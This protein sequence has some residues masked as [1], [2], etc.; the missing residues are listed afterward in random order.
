VELGTLVIVGVT[1]DPWEG[2]ATRNLGSS[3]SFCPL[4]WGNLKLSFYKGKREKY[5]SILFDVFKPRHWL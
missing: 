1:V 4:P 2:N 5:S 3:S